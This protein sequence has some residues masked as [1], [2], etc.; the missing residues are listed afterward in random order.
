[1]ILPTTMVYILKFMLGKVRQRGFKL[2]M[3]VNM[4]NRKTPAALNSEAWE[5]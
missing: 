1:M 2:T 5:S 3:R 4:L